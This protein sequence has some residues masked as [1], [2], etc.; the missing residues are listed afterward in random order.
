[1]NAIEYFY[2]DT[3]NSEKLAEEAVISLLERLDPHSAYLTTEE[4][5]EKTDPLKGNFD[6][7]GIQFNML[8][9]TLY[10]VSVIPG[11][12][13]EKVGLLAGD[14]IIM[15]NDTIIA[16]VKMKNN[17]VMSRLKGPKGTVVNVEVMRGKNTKLLPFRIVRDK[18][19]VYSLDASYMVDAKTGYI[20]INRFASTT[21]DEFAEALV[22]LNAQ[23]ME[24]LILDL[25]GNGGGYLIAA[26]DMAN[27]FLQRGNIITYTQGSHS[28][29]ENF[30]ASYRGTLTGDQRL[31]VLVD[32]SS[33]SASEIVAGAMQDW[34][35]G[36]LVGR[37]TY[38]KGLVQRPFPLGDGSE[39]H[40]TVARYYTPVGRSIQKPYEKGDSESYNKELID[41]YNHGE[42]MHAD[43]IHFPDSLKYN[44]LN[45]NRIVYGG[46]GIM[47]D[48]FIPID[49][50]R[51]NELHRAIIG[52]GTFNKYVLDL[53]DKNREEYN[54]K[55]KD[56]DTFNKQFTVTDAMIREMVKRY[57]KEREEDDTLPAYTDEDVDFLLK[58]R[59]MIRIMVKGFVARDLW[60]MSEFYQV[61]NEDNESLK[62]AI[63]IINNPGEYN[64]LLGK[65]GE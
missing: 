28:K 50:L 51:S 13:S 9:D 44:T 31:V 52:T 1:M 48:Y 43:S 4:V 5:R 24:N 46:G 8:T 47:P 10:V 58:P 40:L 59:S 23:G 3:I 37:R 33:A 56:F 12:P 14:R 27:E 64:K 18:I 65:T 61:V 35:R 41:R 19:P 6:G 32:E 16:G 57:D 42:L 38:G 62:K 25:Q 7:I 2:V 20:K 15:V 11:G 55:Y 45:N 34:D 21:Y 17:D 49:T 53:V 30:T 54:L 26:V 60:D 22:K 36:V 63:E 29:R 39:I